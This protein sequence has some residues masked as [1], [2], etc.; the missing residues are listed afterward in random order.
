MPALFGLRPK[1]I[2]RGAEVGR[3]GL[4]IDVFR[5]LKMSLDRGFAVTLGSWRFGWIG[6]RSMKD[7]LSLLDAIHLPLNR[8]EYQ[9]GGGLTHCNA[10]VNEVC[11]AIGWKSFD[12]LLANQ[13]IDL[14]VSSDQWTE[15]PLE[16]CQFL[17]NQGT[18]VI[19]ALKADPHGHINIICPGKEKTSGRWGLVP[20]CANVGKEVFIGKGINWAFSDMPKFYAWRPSL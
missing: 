8:P 16:K 20:S 15:T 12:G 5:F 17:A 4:Q 13:I 11:Q 6:Y 9:P 19:A 10:Y 7:Q 3:G 1:T 2:L 14:M 18:L